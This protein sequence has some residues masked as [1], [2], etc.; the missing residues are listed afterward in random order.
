MKYKSKKIGAT[1]AKKR[2]IEI[3][4]DV[5]DLGQPTKW[6]IVCLALYNIILKVSS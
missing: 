4:I 3:E 5:G 1:C 2:P 6:G